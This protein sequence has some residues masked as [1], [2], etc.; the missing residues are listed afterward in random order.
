MKEKEM[1]LKEMLKIINDIDWK[2]IVNY[3]QNLQQRIDKVITK[4]DDI[5]VSDLQD[6]KLMEKKLKD[7]KS[8]LQGEE[9]K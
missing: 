1:L 3:I 8:I 5:S 7:I 4:I 2:G 9:E 6:L